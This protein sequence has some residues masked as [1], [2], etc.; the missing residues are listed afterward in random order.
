[1]KKTR[2]RRLELVAWV[3]N[4]ARMI[5]A[6]HAEL[7]AI[8]RARKAYRR[9]EV[10]LQARQDWVRS[11]KGRAFVAARRQP[12]L[13]AAADV[14]RQR[15][16]LE[17]KI[18]RM[19]NRIG[20]AGRTIS[21]LRLAHELGQRELRVP[22]QSPDETRFFRDIGRYVDRPVDRHPDRRSRLPLSA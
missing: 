18:K 3:R 1:M 7:N 16:T 9:A 20:L 15:R 21:D 22:N 14:V 5:W 10:G 13:E 17:R 12:D 19:D 8:G 2:S 4:L 11:P 6:K